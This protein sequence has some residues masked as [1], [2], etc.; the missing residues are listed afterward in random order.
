MK[1]RTMSKRAESAVRQLAEYLCI[2]QLKR[3][4][5]KYG[6][7]LEL[8]TIDPQHQMHYWHGGETA[9]IHYKEHTFVISADG[10]VRATLYATDNRELAY[11]KDKSNLGHFYDAMSPYIRND[12]H[13]TELTDNGQLVFDDGNWWECFLRMPD[14]STRDLMWALDAYKLSEAIVEVAKAMDSIL[15]D[16]KE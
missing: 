1:K 9:Y 5:R 4:V 12:S 8:D 16:I 13:L 15:A 3:D 2:Q 14:G 7:E 10:D 11:V 6:G